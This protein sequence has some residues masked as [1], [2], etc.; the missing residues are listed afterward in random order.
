MTFIEKKAIPS[1]L[2]IKDLCFEKYSRA[3]C[4]QMLTRRITNTGVCG[5][6]HSTAPFLSFAPE[7]RCGGVAE[8]Q[9]LNRAHPWVRRLRSF[10]F[11]YLGRS[12]NLAERYPSPRRRAAVLTVAARDSSLRFL[13]TFSFP[14]SLLTIPHIL[15]AVAVSGADKTK[16]NRRE[17]EQCCRRELTVTPEIPTPVQGE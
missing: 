14:R 6:Y 8:I 1:K 9:T 7:G 16:N 2:V 10:F 5:P 17:Y 11:F 13:R 12:L 3:P 4:A 15:R